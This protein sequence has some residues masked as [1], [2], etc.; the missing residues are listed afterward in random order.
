MERTVPSTESEEVELYTRTY[1]SLLRSSA[2]VKIRTLEEVHA[3]T[4]SLLHPEAREYRSDMAA[5]IYSILRLPTCMP[6]VKLVVLGQSAEIFAGAGLSDIT[7]WKEVFS[8][9]RRRR[10]FFNGQGTLGY[11]ITAARISTISSR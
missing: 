7:S 10:S 6:D 1:Y 2:E 5:F 4:N 8:E 11:F 9:A 3:G